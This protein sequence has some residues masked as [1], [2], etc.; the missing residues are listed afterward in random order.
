[1]CQSFML[2]LPKS[3]CVSAIS[4]TKSLFF[5]DLFVIFQCH[6]QLLQWLFAPI[7]CLF[8]IERQ[9]WLKNKGFIVNAWCLMSNHLHLIFPGEGRLKK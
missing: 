1:M 3:G 2:F 8:C 7:F 5:R 9:Y 4:C 6:D